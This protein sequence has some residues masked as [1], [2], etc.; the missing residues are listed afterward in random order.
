MAAA[1]RLATP[2]ARLRRTALVALLAVAGAAIATS[3]ARRAEARSA[4]QPRVV[5]LARADAAK[6][7]HVKLS[8][9]RVVRVTSRTWP[10]TCLGL[11]R[12]GEMCGQVV[13]RGYRVTFSVRGRRVVYRTDRHTALR[14]ESG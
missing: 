2:A 8:Q 3:H 13:T 6:R 14:H 10:D 7:K 11:P 12:A 1:M 4:G 9:V 5:R